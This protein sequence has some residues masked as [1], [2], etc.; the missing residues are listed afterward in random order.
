M[1]GKHISFETMMMF[2]KD[3]CMYK[4]EVILL[5]ITVFFSERITYIVT[6]LRDS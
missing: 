2:I 3:S 5:S 4:T 1:E 6:S